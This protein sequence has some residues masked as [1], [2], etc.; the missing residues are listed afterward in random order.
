MSK[1]IDFDN[2][3]NVG[4]NGMGSGLAMLWNNE[5]D[6]NIFSYSNHHIDAMIHR[7]NGKNWRRSGIYSH[8]E[9][10]QKRHT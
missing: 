7:V 5:V 4:K 8:M 10:M 6:V 3:F 9:I 2:C 1:N